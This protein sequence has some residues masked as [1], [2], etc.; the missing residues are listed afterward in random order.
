MQGTIV[1]F[2]TTERSLSKYLSSWATPIDLLTNLLFISFSSFAE[3]NWALVMVDDNNKLVPTGTNSTNN[4]AVG[5]WRDLGVVLED[6]AVTN[7][8]GW[9]AVFRVDNVTQAPLG[10]VGRHPYDSIETDIDFGQQQPDA[11]K[12]P[13]PWIQPSFG[14]PFDVWVGSIVLIG[15]DFGE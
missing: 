7:T 1:K 6:R 14:Y 3:I 9:N 8:T 4:V 2:D 11:G 15:N 5:I 10:V 13:N 12:K